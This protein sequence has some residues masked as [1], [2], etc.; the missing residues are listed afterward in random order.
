MV[1]QYVHGHTL[2]IAGGINFCIDFKRGRLI[3]FCTKLHKQGWV[4]FLAQTK[5]RWVSIF[6]KNQGGGGGG[7]SYTFWHK[8]Q[9]GHINFCINSS[10]RGE[11]QFLHEL[12][13]RRLSIFE[14]SPGG[15]GEYLFLYKW[16]VTDFITTLMEII[17]FCI[18]YFGTTTRGW[19]LLIFAQIPRV[20]Y[21]SLQNEI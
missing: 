19:K 18:K 1:I 21:Q 4:I 5:R 15:G 3:H 11:Y 20:C 13:G 12:N 16:G 8:L 2:F 6:R 14:Q 10:R 17:I 9:G 7:A